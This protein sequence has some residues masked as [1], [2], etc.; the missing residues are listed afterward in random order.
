MSAVSLSSSTSF[1]QFVLSQAHQNLMWVASSDTS[2]RIRTR[3]SYSGQAEDDTVLVP[4]YEC[5]HFTRLLVLILIRIHYDLRTTIDIEMKS[6][7]RR[8]LIRAKAKSAPRRT[9]ILTRT[10]PG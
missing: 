8:V 6:A 7:R 1:V 5:M 3:T 2:H 9:R 4:L 10:S